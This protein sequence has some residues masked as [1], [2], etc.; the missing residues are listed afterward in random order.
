VD[1][2]GDG[3]AA[4]A[5]VTST[6]YDAVFMDQHMPGLDGLAATSRLRELEYADLPIVAMTAA[7]FDDDRRA[8]LAAGMTHV[9]PKPWSAEQLE[10][11]LQL[12]QDR[13]SIA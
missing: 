4:V 7:A 9:L 10:D 1:V 3:E 13:A 6:S 11:V 8:C 12:L 2:V 5:A